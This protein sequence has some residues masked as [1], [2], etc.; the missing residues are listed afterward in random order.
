M[1]LQGKRAAKMDT[2]GW[3]AQKRPV[4][5]GRYAEKKFPRWLQWCGIV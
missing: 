3:N 5:F 2:R 1:K 4:G